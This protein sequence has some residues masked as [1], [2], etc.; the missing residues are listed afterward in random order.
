MNRA[1]PGEDLAGVQHF[2]PVELTSTSCRAHV[3]L[4]RY[5]GGPVTDADLGS[6][7]IDTTP[8]YKNLLSVWA[9]EDAYGLGH[10]LTQ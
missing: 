6:I 8:G 10:H 7:R 3:H 2:D 9:V 5:R 4:H 1:E